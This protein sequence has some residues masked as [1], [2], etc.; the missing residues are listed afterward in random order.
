MCGF[1]GFTNPLSKVQGESILNKMLDPIKHRGPDSNCFYLNDKIAMGHYRLSIIDLEGGKQPRIDKENHHHLLYNGEIYGYKNHAKILN[2]QG[3]I[4]EDNSDTE[5]LFQSLK[6]FGVEETLK[7]ID[8][9]FSFVFYESK[10][11]S[12]WLARDPMGEKPLY[13]AINNNKVFFSSELSSLATCSNLLSF[14]IDEN[15]IMSYLNLDYI[16]KDKTILSGIQKVLPGELIK[17]QKGNISKKF[18]YKIDFNFKTSINKYDAISQMDELLS[19]SVKERLIADVPLGIFLSGGIDSSL[20]AYYAKKF[21]NNI[22]SYTIKM[23]NDSYDESSY[24]KLVANSLGIENKVAEFDDEAIISSLD[25]IEKKLDEPL[26]DPSILPTFLLSKFAKE[27][28]KVVLSGDGAD[29]L[30]CGYAP[31]KAINY[32]KFLSLIPK[33]VGDKI[34]LYTE[35]FASKDNYMSYHF[36]LKHVSRGFGWPNYQQVFR[37]MSPLS[38]RDINSLLNKDFINDYEPRKKWD[39]LIF[40]EENIKLKLPD[41]LSKLFIDYYLPNDILTKVDRASMYNGLEV[42]SPFLSKSILTF[43]QKLPNKYK[44]ANNQTKFI[45]RQLADKILPKS[46]STRKKHGFAIPLARMIRGPLKERVEDTLLS[47]SYPVSKYFDRSKLENL[48]KNHS[49]GIDNRKPIWA[50]YMLYKN[51]ERLAKLS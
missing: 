48:I 45:L 32:L 14:S 46:I 20:I 21:K 4:L 39:E 15:S 16:P 37:W 31:F 17:I 42:R 24:A 13:Y 23:N 44:L 9:M 28:V 25:I 34:S 49:K 40:I 19:H 22:K 50:I 3:I 38:D 8:G 51:T 6:H 18:Y 5:V 47:S 43:S 35:K 2:G 41:V 11:D 12:L 33:V 26:S 27:E 30:F 36:L 7:K 10:S 29:E 1:A